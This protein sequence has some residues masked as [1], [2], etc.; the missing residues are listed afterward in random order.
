[1]ALTSHEIEA[2]ARRV[3]EL[4]GRP[5]GLVDA[6]D[7]ADDL[8]VERDWVYAHA[9]ELGAVRLGDGPKARLRFDLQRVRDGLAELGRTDSPGR[10]SQRTAESAADRGEAH[11]GEVQTVTDGRETITTVNHIGP[12]G[13]PT[14]PGPAPEVESDASC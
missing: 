7:V 13:A 8:K 5:S 11:P 10:A 12:A 9:R 14:P 4:V 1:M 6:Q 3:A 2:I